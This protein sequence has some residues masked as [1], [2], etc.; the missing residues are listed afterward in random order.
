M[1]KEQKFSERLGNQ[2]N[3][4]DEETFEQGPLEVRK[5]SE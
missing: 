4:T 1:V 3:A 2:E 5:H